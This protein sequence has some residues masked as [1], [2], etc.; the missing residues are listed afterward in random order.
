MDSTNEGIPD[1]VLYETVAL[2]WIHRCGAF[3]KKKDVSILDQMVSVVMSPAPAVV[4]IFRC[5]H[6][7]IYTSMYTPEHTCLATHTY[8]VESAHSLHLCAAFPPWRGSKRRN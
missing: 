1:D 7:K 4:R 3:S 8:N 5:I 6:K 2:W